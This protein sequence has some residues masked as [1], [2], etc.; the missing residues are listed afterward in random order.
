MEQREELGLQIYSRSISWALYLMAHQLHSWLVEYT[1]LIAQI[2]IACL[3]VS[4]QTTGHLLHV[5]KLKE[6]R[7]AETACMFRSSRL[8][9]IWDCF[10]RGSSLCFPMILSEAE[11]GCGILPTHISSCCWRSWDDS[12]SAHTGQPVATPAQT[13]MSSSLIFDFEK[14]SYGSVGN[15]PFGLP[16]LLWAYLSLGLSS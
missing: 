13:N 3:V 12:R 9:G 5:W 4:P 14:Q 15:G 6:R 1:F 11:A 10:P 16:A 8:L 2:C 7:T